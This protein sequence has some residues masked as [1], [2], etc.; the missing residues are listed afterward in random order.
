MKSAK[1]CYNYFSPSVLSRLML[2]RA[3][4]ERRERKAWN[5]TPAALRFSKHVL[6]QR[7]DA[8]SSIRAANVNPSPP[9]CLLA[10]SSDDWRGSDESISS[11]MGIITIIISIQRWRKRSRKGGVHSARRHIGNRDASSP[12]D[13]GRERQSYSQVA[14]EAAPAKM[15]QLNCKSA[16][17]LDNRRSHTD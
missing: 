9:A 14:T 6:R 11:S 7:S 3:K 13:I 5:R 15:T 8:S 1:N 4:K 10:W 16:S 2:Q 17:S 12:S